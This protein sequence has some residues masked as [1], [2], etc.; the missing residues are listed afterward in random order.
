[1]IEKFIAIKEMIK[2]DNSRLH[3]LNLRN[4]TCIDELHIISRLVQLLK[5]KVK[6]E[7][8]QTSISY[9][10]RDDGFAA[11]I[12]LVAHDRKNPI[13]LLVITSEDNNAENP[14][15]ISSYAQKIIHQANIPVLVIKRETVRQ[16]KEAVLTE[17]ERQ[18]NHN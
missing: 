12:L 13:D 6:K 18:L 4:P 16:S 14:F 1:M 15:F 11:K 3:V 9:Y 17:F 7:N 5:I 8:I 10:F 2:K